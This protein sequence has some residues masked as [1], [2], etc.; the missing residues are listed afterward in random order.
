VALWPEEYEAFRADA[1][2]MASTLASRFSAFV[3]D[4]VPSDRME[5]LALQRRAV[6][7]MVRN[8][9]VVTRSSAGCRAGSSERRMSQVV[10][11]SISMAVR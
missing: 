2:D 3:G 10:S 5:R 8:S 9:R 4:L 6:D 7:A 1:R 11:T